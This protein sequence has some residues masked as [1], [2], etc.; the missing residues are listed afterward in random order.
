MG[1]IYGAS[2]GPETVLD[3]KDED[4][5]EMKRIITEQM[6]TI[7]WF[8]M[9]TALAPGYMKKVAKRDEGGQQTRQ[10]EILLKWIE[11]RE[12]SKVKSEEPSFID[13]MFQSNVDKETAISDIVMT[14]AAGA[15]T[16]AAGVVN[17]L[18]TLAKYPNV[19]QQI[20][21]ELRK[22]NGDKDELE[23][24]KKEDFRR[25]HENAHTL[26]AFIEETW[27]LPLIS[28]GNPRTLADDFKMEVEINGKKDFYILPKGAF[29]DFNGPYLTRSKQS[30]WKTPLAFD[31]GNY[32][33]KNG[34]FRNPVSGLD[35]FGYGGRDCPGMQ[36]ARKENMFAIA[37]ILYDY[38]ICGP[39]GD[40]DVDFNVPWFGVVPPPFSLTMIKR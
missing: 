9:M 39:K 30:G 20:Y 18:Y 40:G 35:C 5:L 4:Y 28:T 2:F 13:M 15:H 38:K 11:R 19:Q 25:L 8:F 22:I 36:L 32:L 27:R 34:K 33:D 26:R 7:L 16:T 6:A 21:D 31:I 3:P 29:V 14:F 37:L 1:T 10:R 24:T 12:N 23:M 17:Q